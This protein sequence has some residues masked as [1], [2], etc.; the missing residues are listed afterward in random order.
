MGIDPFDLNYEL[1]TALDERVLAEA[2][3]GDGDGGRHAQRDAETAHSLQVARQI[4]EG[5]GE[6]FICR[7]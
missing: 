7:E 1:Q 3:S 5:L 6:F 4:K 2:A